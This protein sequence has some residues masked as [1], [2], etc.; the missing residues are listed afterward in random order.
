MGNI[1]IVHESPGY[2][3]QL[4]TRNPDLCNRLNRHSNFQVELSVSKI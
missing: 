2:M 1:Q 4:L 3:K